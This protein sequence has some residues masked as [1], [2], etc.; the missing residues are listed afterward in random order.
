MPVRVVWDESDRT[1]GRLSVDDRDVPLPPRGEAQ[2]PLRPRDKEYVI[3]ATRGAFKQEFR[4]KAEAGKSVQP[5]VVQVPPPP[6]RNW[7]RD[8]DK[9]KSAALAANKTIV[10]LFEKLDESGRPLSEKAQQLATSG[11]EQAEGQRHVLMLVDLSQNGSDARTVM[12]QELRRKLKIEDLPAI[13]EVDVRGDPVDGKASDQSGKTKPAGQEAAAGDVAAKPPTESVAQKP[14]T[15]PEKQ[16]PAKKPPEESPPKP[17]AEPPLPDVPAR[18]AD[19]SAEDFLK[20]CGLLKFG[21]SWLLPEDRKL[22][23]E[24][25]R[26]RDLRKR[27][28]EVGELTASALSAEA[29]WD[30]AG[31]ARREATRELDQLMD[32]ARERPAGARDR[33]RTDR[34]ANRGG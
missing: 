11:F 25:Q 31:R 24:V 17:A 14:P 34:Q 4:R 8:F 30:A 7:F 13:V 3:T 22:V 10:I 9:A 27:A 19:M 1:G 33:E 15:S 5:C 16:T 21:R 28:K 23:Q 26:L 18:A 2:Y 6:F 20:S 29:K 32:K 12:G